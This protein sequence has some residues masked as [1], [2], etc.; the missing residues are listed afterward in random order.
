MKEVKRFEIDGVNY[1]LREMSQ[2]YHLL[3]ADNQIPYIF[4]KKELE[5]VKNSTEIVSIRIE[6]AIDFGLGGEE[7][8]KRCE[9]Y[10][11]SILKDD[12][13]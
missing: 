12:K 11:N 8:L 9:R 4:E 3:I 5:G 2:K 6:T 13:A 1:I 10:F 7:A